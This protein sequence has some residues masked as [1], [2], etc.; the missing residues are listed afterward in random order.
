MVKGQV[1]AEGRS[2]LLLYQGLAWIDAI[3]YRI[4]RMRLDLLKPRLD[5]GLERSTTDI[6]FGEV[7]LHRRPLCFGYPGRLLSR[8]STTGRCIGTGISTSISNFSASRARSNPQN[9]RDRVRRIEW[10]AGQSAYNFTRRSRKALVM[11][12]TELKV[13]AALAMIGLKSSPKAG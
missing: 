10:R 1:S 13:M 7:H 6:Q 12:E 3:S 9:L 4:V 11:T 8:P 2:A 5:I